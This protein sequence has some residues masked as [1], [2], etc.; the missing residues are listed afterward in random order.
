MV[1]ACLYLCPTKPLCQ[2][3][4]CLF[5]FEVLLFL[6]I[7]DLQWLT[8]ATIFYFFFYRLAFVMTFVLTCATKCCCFLLRNELTFDLTLNTGLW[9]TSFIK[10]AGGGRPW[11]CILALLFFLSLS[12]SVSPPSPPPLSCSSSLTFSLAVETVTCYL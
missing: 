8:F 11:H 2:S 12:V 7:F 1:S 6:M 3:G 10:T 9:I 4:L 5:W